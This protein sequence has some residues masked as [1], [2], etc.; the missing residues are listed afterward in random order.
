[1]E[2]VTAF[3]LAGGK[4]SRMG[5]DKAFLLIEGQT[6]LQRALENG[7]AVAQEVR[8]VG[9]AKKFTGFAPVVEDV[10]PDRGPL[11]AIHAALLS[12]A[13]QL[14]LIL[15][16]DLPFINPAFLRYLI[17]EAAASEAAITLCETGGRLH[18]LSA[19]YRR[20]FAEVAGRSLEAGRNRI[21]TL[22]SEAGARIISETEMLRA[23]FSPQLL[24]NVNTLSELEAAREGVEPRT[25]SGSQDLR[26]SFR[27]HLREI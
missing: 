13:T 17:A 7:R 10:Y 27:A 15:A 19:V 8:I 21:D 11:G 16:V 20:G 24:H 25:A 14:N 22:F 1:M 23:G 2:P 26:Q 12:S 6:L 9:A 3:I 18:P 4:S 5:A